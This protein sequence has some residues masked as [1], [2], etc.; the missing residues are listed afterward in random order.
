MEF[1]EALPI[2]VLLMGLLYSYF[3]MRCVKVKVGKKALITVIYFFVFV[4]AIAEL[5]FTLTDVYYWRLLYHTSAFV[6]IAFCILYLFLKRFYSLNS[7][8]VLLF[9]II[10]YQLVISIIQGLFVFPMIIVDVVTWPLLF[11]VF[12]DYSIVN[13]LPVSFKR[14]TK[15][16]LAIICLLSI[17]NIVIQY[18]TVKGSAVFTTYFCVTFL[19]ML[20]LLNTGRQAIFFSYLVGGLML[21]SSKRGG[22]IV[23]LLGVGVYYVLLNYVHSKSRGRVI[24]LTKLMIVILFVLLLLSISIEIF[25]LK[26]MDRLF[27]IVDDGGS[28]RI[29][30]WNQILE[31][32]RSSPPA[33]KIFG[34]GFH[35]VF[36]SVVPLG[37]RRYAHN[38]YLETLYDYG[39]IG[40]ILISILVVKITS[41]TV[42]MVKR[43]YP[44]APAMGFSLVSLYVFSLVSYFFEQSIL[45]LPLSVFWGVC[46]GRFSAI[47]KPLGGNRAR[48]RPQRLK[49]IRGD[50]RRPKFPFSRER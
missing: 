41:V 49:S 15:Y 30:I 10:I 42:K 43:K 36:Y 47:P 22:F 48:K 44:L 32:Y 29:R 2:L 7:F 17:P 46:L 16:G 39:A 24:R 28:G 23:V 27:D 11:V 31:R 1:I 34:H 38:S 5:R 50:L 37:I 35:A 33:E 14:I 19:P 4:A 21:F 6:I 9:T 45:I 3:W 40:L 26:I 25:D 20:Y 18:S 8:V 12:L 13:D